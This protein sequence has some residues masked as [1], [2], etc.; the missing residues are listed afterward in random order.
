MSF[1]KD[2]PNRKDH[3]GKYYKSGKFDR[4][5]RPNGGCPYCKGNRGH[6]TEKR[7]LSAEDKLNDQGDAKRD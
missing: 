1:E 6:S 2:Y 5:C 3:R 4:T 7:R